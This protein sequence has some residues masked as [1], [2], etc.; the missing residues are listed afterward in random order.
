[1]YHEG[2]LHS[3]I[4]GLVQELDVMMADFSNICNLEKQIAEYG[5]HIR[6]PEP[7]PLY[8]SGNQFPIECLGCR[9]LGWGKTATEAIEKIPHKQ[10]C[11]Y[12]KD[13]LDEM[14]KKRKWFRGQIE[15]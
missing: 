2:Y 1:M 7:E 15:I 12:L 14:I 11:K 9:E 5:E 13:D 3:R 6:G 4:D 8:K 10:K